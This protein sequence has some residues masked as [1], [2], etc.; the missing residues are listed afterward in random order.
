MLLINCEINL[1]LVVT[2]STQDNIKLLKQLES[3]FTRIMNCNKNQSK[4]TEQAQNKHLDYLFDPSFQ[5]VNI[6]FVLFFE[7]QN[8]RKVHKGYFL[9]KVEIIDYN[10]MITVRNVFDQ[11]VKNDLITND[12][13]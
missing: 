8:D 5:E 4:V 2:L 6:P 13:I 3:G 1:I 9:S 10:V 12:N 11:P 7:K